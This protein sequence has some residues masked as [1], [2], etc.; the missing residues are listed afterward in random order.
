MSLIDVTFIVLGLTLVTALF[1]PKTSVPAPV[2]FAC[3]GIA[4]GV[5]WHLMPFL[6]VIRVPPDLVLFIFLPPLLTT[7]AYAL[8]LQTFRRNLRPIALLAIGL[9]LATIGAVA[10]IGHFLVGL[11]WAAAVVLGAIL[12]PPD[13]V[14]ATAVAGKTGLSHRLV[15]ILEGEGLVNDAVAIVAYGVALEA[16]TTGKFEA[17][18][19]LLALLQEVPIGVAVGLAAGWIA[20]LL[21]RRIDSVPLEIG[22][23]LATPYLAYHLADRFGGS[24]VLAVVTLGFML[25]SSSA[26]VSSPVAR[27]AARTVWSFLRYVS[28]ALVFVLLGLLIGEIAVNWPGWAVVRAGI[29]LGA[30]VIV[31]R[32]AWMLMVPRLV[33]IFGIGHDSVPSLGERFVLG[34]AGMRGVVSLALA[35]ALPLAFGGDGELRST[36]IFLTLIVIIA[37][38]LFQGIT[39]LPLVQRLQVGDPDREARE[40]CS[41]RIR[42]RRASI[43]AVKKSGGGSGDLIARLESGSIG[44][45]SAGALGRHAEHG[46]ALLQALDAQ[47]K[48]VNSLRDAGRMGSALAE[49]L[50]TELDLDAMNATGDGARLTNAGEE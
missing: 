48:V 29:I 6:P 30:A 40:E 35:L 4:V 47:R 46:P 25:R 22:I 36:I 27:L 1:T 41:A 14:A 3:A 18:H 17:T 49:R 11:G 31:V 10:L 12:A 9:V 39:L 21:R 33:A 37:T 8:P 2:V 45:A 44:I 13:P 20:G 23:S 38:L 34:W 28:T 24:A 7:A 5:V 26:R 19:A 15:V 50:D 42:A 32:L 43:A 16:L